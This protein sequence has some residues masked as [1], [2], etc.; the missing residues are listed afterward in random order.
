M[1]KLG[2]FYDALEGEARKGATEKIVG[3]CYGWLG[4][5]ATEEEREELNVIVSD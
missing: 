2:E 1:A 5:V 3:D 4:E